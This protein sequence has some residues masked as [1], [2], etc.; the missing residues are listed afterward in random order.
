MKLVTFQSLDAVKDLFEKGYL[1]CN[2]SKIDIKKAGPTYNWVIEK[3]N[4]LVK[5]AIS[6][7]FIGYLLVG[8]LGARQSVTVFTLVLAGGFGYMIKIIY[9]LMNHRPEEMQHQFIIKGGRKEKGGD[10]VEAKN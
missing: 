1:E 2:R 3:M 9:K 7:I 8:L 5:I 10:T 6:M 4:K